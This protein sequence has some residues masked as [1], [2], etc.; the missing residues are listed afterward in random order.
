[1]KYEVNIDTHQLVSYNVRHFI[2]FD[3]D[4]LSLFV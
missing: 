2:V 3:L 4:V 1:L